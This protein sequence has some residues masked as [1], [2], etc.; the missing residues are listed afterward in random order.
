[1]LI[2]FSYFTQIFCVIESYLF[3]FFHIMEKYV[4][5]RS[6]YKHLFHLLQFLIFKEKK[7][8]DKY[9]FKFLILLSNK[10]LIL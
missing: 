4:I 10:K 2:Y 3:V 1:M 6:H 5:I 8:F 7:M 9:Y